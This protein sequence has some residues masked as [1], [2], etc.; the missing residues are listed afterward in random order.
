[1]VDVQPLQ[2]L[3]EGKGKQI[4]LLYGTNTNETNVFVSLLGKSGVSEAEYVAVVAELF[5]LHI[6]K[7][8]HRFPPHFLENATLTTAYLAT[9]YLFTCANDYAFKNHG[10]SVFTYEFDHPMSFGHQWWNPNFYCYNATCHAGEIPFV[11]SSAEFM[12]YQI[13]DDEKVLSVELAKY[14]VNL[15]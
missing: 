10:P 8:L 13:T 1:V 9:E 3:H 4:P 14:W 11:F 2:L 7:V 5:P 15:C 6:Y 12:G